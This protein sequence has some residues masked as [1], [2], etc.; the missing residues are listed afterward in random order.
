MKSI[1]VVLIFALVSFK[2]FAGQ[3][4][5][6]DFLWLD[7]DKKVYVLQNKVYEK[8]GTAYVT[9]GY[10]KGLSTDFQDTKVY[11][12]KT[13]YYFSED[14]GIELLYSGKNHSNDDA[15]A[16]ITD[17]T[18][19][20][21]KIPFVRRFKS[22]YGAMGLWSPFYGKINTFNEIFYFDVNFGLGI[23][24]IDAESNRT[25]FQANSATDVYEDESY[26][27]G[28][29]KVGMRF[30]VTESLSL[31]LDFTT[32]TYKANSGTSDVEKYRNNT[33]G[34]LSIGWSF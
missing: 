2:S 31:D 13:G 6:Y 34:T 25:A 22:Y 11:Q 19:G 32:N 17:A 16:T 4:D 21:N 14:W 9:A 1:L 18:N 26:T 33:D 24:K 27:A 20:N 3:D 30:Y 10:G 8:K 23:S 5:L 28:L 7:P 12:F 15:Y 29:W